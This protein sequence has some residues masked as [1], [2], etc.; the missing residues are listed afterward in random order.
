MQSGLGRTGRMFAFEHEDARPDGLILGKALGGGLLPVSAFVAK[1]ELMDVFEPG[2]HGSTF[3]GNPLAMAVACEA[4]RVLQDENLVARSH[5]QG[6]ILR[7]ALAHIAH[8]AI[9][10]VRGKGLWVGVE[11]D[12]EA[13]GRQGCLPGD[14]AAR[15]LDQGD[16]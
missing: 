3:G 11:L 7:E 16:A 4:M 14:G 5:A 12:R 6:E 13:G 15:R 1:R 10:A 8:P 9:R 2:S